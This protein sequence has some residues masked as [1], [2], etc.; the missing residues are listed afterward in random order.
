MQ[1]KQEILKQYFGYTAFR[2]GQE[3]IIDAI[4]EGRDAVGIMPT[5]AG[6]SLCFQVPALLLPGITLVVSPLISLM[7]DQVNALTQNGVNAAFL[8][9]SLSSRQYAKALYNASLGLYKIIYVA[10]ERLLTE[11]FQSFALETQ[12]SMVTV[13]EAHCVSQWGQ[14]FRPSY[15]AVAE[16]LDVLPARPVVSAFT[17]TATP[18]VR[19]DIAALLKLRD[20][21]IL[22]TGFDRENLYFEVRRPKDKTAAVL[23]L[24]AGMAGKSGIIYCA[25]RKNVEELCQTLCRNG[26]TATR[27]HAGL[28]DRERKENQDAF[29]YDRCA[30]MVATNAFG[31]GIDKSNVSFVI[32]YNMPKDL[33][34]YYQ[35]AGRAGRD[36]EPAN[37]ILLYSGQDVA[38]NQFLIDHADENE[39]MDEAQKALVRQQNV[40]RLKAM[41]FY[42]HTNDCLREYILKYFGERAP[43]FC[44]NCFNCNHLF[45]TLDITVPAQMILSCVK[46]TGGRYGIKV[47]VDTL[48]GS[49]N[50]KILRLG[51][52]KQS[53]YGLMTDTN[54]HRLREMIQFL[55][56]E[57]YL[58][59]SE[60][61]FP[62]LI[63]GGRADE[64]LRERRELTMKLAKEEERIKA[65][66]KGPVETLQRPA[67]FEEL[68]ALR[69][70]LAAAQNMPSYVVFSNAS[71]EDMCAKMPRTPAEFL[72]VSGVG[73]QK[74]ERYGEEFL[75]VIREYSDH[76]ELDLR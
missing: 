23:K 30:I 24:L 18:K 59:V 41:T 27:Y 31:M 20:P 49:R 52:D 67:L 13:D 40:R 39:S 3:S 58:A 51:L 70:K 44:G 55:I 2:A 38:M 76:E 69:S 21:Y 29:L 4:L 74:L 68:R 61:E 65:P 17:A 8:N 9:S 75:A 43:V 63:L 66:A 53:T 73:K 11:E 28:P 72:M 54:E 46:R 47:V 22:L 12:I 64:I 60:G 14:D 19:E 34:S 26:Y 33:E 45:E 71:L 37:C 42:C 5:G 16:F 10:P 35:E 50:E 36:G 32:H 1:T 62:L 7:K 57:G 48:R 6:K 15:L 25:T 56:L